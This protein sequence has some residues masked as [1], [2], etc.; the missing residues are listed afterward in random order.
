[1]C[2]TGSQTYYWNSETQQ[3][4]W[5]PPPGFWRGDVWW[6][7]DQWVAHADA[8]REQ[9]QEQA[10]AELIS[11]VATSVAAFSALASKAP[12]ASAVP[13]PKLKKR[14][15]TRPPFRFV[16]ELIASTSACSGFPPELCVPIER[17]KDTAAKADFLRGI[18]R[19]VNEDTGIELFGDDIAQT[20]CEGRECINTN[21]FLQALAACAVRAQAVCGVGEAAEAERKA[22]QLDTRAEAKR[23]KADVQVK[24]ER[25][26][27]MELQAKSAQLDEAQRLLQESRDTAESERAK[28]KADV[29]AQYEHKLE[30]I[31]KAHA[32]ELEELQ[33]AAADRERARKEAR[34]QRKSKR[35]QDEAQAKHGSAPHTSAAGDALPDDP[36]AFE[37]APTA[38]PSALASVATPLCTPAAASAPAPA[39]SSALAT[40]AAAKPA[41]AQVLGLAVP[42]P[43]PSLASPVPAHTVLHA[44][45]HSS[46]ALGRRGSVA[47]VTWAPPSVRA[48]AEHALSLT[49]LAFLAN[50]GRTVDADA[51]TV[52]VAAAPGARRISLAR[53]VVSA[54]RFYS[55]SDDDD[56]RSGMSQV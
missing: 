52:T 48:P 43:A 18:I 27:S 29:A 23:A 19:S 22:V 31:A 55:D 56:A 2:E 33:L 9:R 44:P 6:T 47:P 25:A 39:P 16:H 54:P 15:F 30:N 10:N 8:E 26:K 17:L 51:R 35:K 46:V 42:D 11:A 1:M 34:A 45:C 7:L 53:T 24:E 21:R 13:W 4:S 14:Y 50:V 40:P 36:L 32:Q 37:A 12:K 5:L 49:S 3:S 38:A 41:P 20:I 28:A